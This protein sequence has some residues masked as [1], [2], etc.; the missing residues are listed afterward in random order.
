MF[1]VSVGY[2]AHSSPTAGFVHVLCDTIRRLQN[3]VFIQLSYLFFHGY[4]ALC[5][6]VS[7]SRVY[8]SLLTPGSQSCMFIVYFWRLPCGEVV[9]PGISSKD[10][11]RV[12]PSMWG[13]GDRT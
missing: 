7:V 1:T 10:V 2:N 9:S 8:R 5:N 12:R 6:I 11:V 13:C 3:V 4:I